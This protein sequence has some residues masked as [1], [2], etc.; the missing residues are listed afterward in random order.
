MAVRIE[1]D[2]GRV[3]RNAAAIAAATGVPILAVVKADAYGLGATPVAEALTDLGDRLGGF[4]VFD[5]AEAVAADLYRRTGRRTI[6]LHGDSTDADDYRSAHVHPVVWTADRAAALRG[7]RPVLSLDTG[8][9]RFGCPAVDADVVLRAGDC[10]EAMTH[11][12]RP[13]QAEH[14]RRFAATVPER[15]VLHAAGSALLGT[16]AAWFDAVRPGL[17]LYA[18]A[19]RASAPLVEVRD[20]AGPAGYTGFCVSRF[21]VVRAGYRDGLRPGPCRVG[22][23]PSRVLEVGMQSAF[24]ELAAGDRAGDEV[25]FLGCDDAA[26]APDDLSGGRSGGAVS[27][28][29]LSRAWGV[30][31]QEVLVRL[32]AGGARQYRG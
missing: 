3:R 14:L 26:A 21:G 10:P 22:G 31:P 16:P 4:Y 32:T 30:S 17:A 7:A 23:R 28:T 19:V 2:L 1:I 15:L 5:A 29:D 9:Q 12:T 25:M 20:A 11:A 8:Q 27:E 24:V 18:G 13:E 6:A